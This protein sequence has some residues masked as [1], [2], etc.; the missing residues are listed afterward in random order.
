MLLQQQ[1]YEEALFVS[2]KSNNRI[3]LNIEPGNKIVVQLRELLPRSIDKSKKYS[4]NF[5]IEHERLEEDA[6]GLGEQE[7]EGSSE[8]GDEDL[9]E[10]SDSSNY[11]YEDHPTSEEESEEMSEDDQ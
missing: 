6:L 7:D 5:E 4:G 10:D 3:V 11:H 1:E 8:E 2:D 9:S